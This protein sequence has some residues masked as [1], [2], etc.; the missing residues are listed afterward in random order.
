MLWVPEELR[1][2]LNQAW[3]ENRKRVNRMEVGRTI[4]RM[5]MLPALI[6]FNEDSQM[7]G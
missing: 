6:K 1:D 5:L 3:H 2:K 7:P 4:P